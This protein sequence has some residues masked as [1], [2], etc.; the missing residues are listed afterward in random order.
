MKY[1]IDKQRKFNVGDVIRFNKK[2]TK[3]SGLFSTEWR[4]P[5]GTVAT[6]VGIYNGIFGYGCYLFNADDTIPDA[7]HEVFSCGRYH[8]KLLCRIGFEEVE[9]HCSRVASS[10]QFTHLEGI[11]CGETA[12]FREHNRFKFKL[13]DV[14]RFTGD[15]E[16]QLNFGSIVG[17]DVKTGYTARVEHVGVAGWPI[18]T[19]Y[20][21]PS[22]NYLLEFVTPTVHEW[23]RVDRRAVERVFTK[24]P[25]H[26][27]A[28]EEHIEPRF[29]K[30]NIGD[31]IVCTEQ[32]TLG[33][34][35]KSRTYEPGCTM[36]VVGYGDEIE[37]TLEMYKLKF[38]CDGITDEGYDDVIT[39][40]VCEDHFRKL[41]I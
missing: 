22:D 37:P 21:S 28:H 7:A 33:M 9:E 20:Y 3:K 40:N 23:R 39:Y 11:L 24:V 30:F 31:I 38:L 29:P 4:I 12:Q 5:K 6:V 8:P 41:E 19:D 14:I 27:G 32:L 35:V 25:S 17:F 18:D 15:D 13:G 10:C 36:K 2:L 34:G 1:D 16:D 26:T